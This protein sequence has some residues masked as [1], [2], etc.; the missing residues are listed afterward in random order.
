M[1][2][3]PTQVI[4]ARHMKFLSFCIE[5]LSFANSHLNI[6][7]LPRPQ[8]LTS[9]LILA[10]LLFQGD[11][12][13]LVLSPAHSIIKIFQLLFLVFFSKENSLPGY[14]RLDL[15]DVIFL[16]SLISYFATQS[17][18]DT[19]LPAVS[20]ESHVICFCVLPYFF[21]IFPRRITL[22]REFSSG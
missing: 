1:E 10:S 19:E 6:S 22:K 13:F 21:H 12:L 7:S 4:Q 2:T 15:I 14:V 3:P 9:T 8:T 16:T 17:Y 11:Y 20:R 18:N 5:S